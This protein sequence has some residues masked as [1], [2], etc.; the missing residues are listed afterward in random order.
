MK[1]KTTYL[2]TGVLVTLATLFLG[3]SK[4][5]PYRPVSFSPLTIVQEDLQASIKRGK[6]LYT[7]NCA[8]CHMANGEGIKGVFPPLAKSDYY[9][10]DK[11]RAIRS[12]LYGVKGKMI[13]NGVEYN[14]QMAAY[15]FKDD[16]LADLMNY[17]GNSWGNQAQRVEPTEIA[18][19]RKE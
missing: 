2:I 6:D 9:S 4:I 19:A 11:A 10:T 12:I 17:I 13:V 18:A 1:G 7:A 14:G 15:P 8:S 5:N 16:Q 3:F